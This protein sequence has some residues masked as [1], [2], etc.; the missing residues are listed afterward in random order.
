MV[1]RAKMASRSA[2]SAAICSR[3]KFEAVELANNLR[4]QLWKQGMAIARGRTIQLLA[5]ITM[6]RLIIENALGEE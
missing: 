4:L 1:A 3:I 6:R 5:A 2:S